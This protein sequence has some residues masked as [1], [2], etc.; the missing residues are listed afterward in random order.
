[1]LLVSLLVGAAGRVACCQLAH[2]FRVPQAAGHPGH[3]RQAAGSR[4]L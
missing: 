1:M 2:S 3:A 4:G